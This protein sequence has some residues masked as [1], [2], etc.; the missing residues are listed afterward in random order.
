MSAQSKYEIVAL[1]NIEVTVDVSLLLKNDELFFNAT[2]IAKQFNKKPNEWL[3]SKQASEYIAVILEAENFRYENLVRTATGGKYQGTWLHKKLAL[4]FARWLSVKFEYEL[5]QWIVSR[6]KQEND[7][8]QQ[9]LEARTG[10]L[11]L[12][13]AIQS[14]HAEPKSYHFSNECNL[15]NRIVTGMDAKA[16]KEVHGVDSV[17]DAL[18]A[19][20]LRRMNE[21]QA[22][23]TALIKLGFDYDRRKELLTQFNVNALAA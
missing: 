17:R 8:K 1:N 21:L 7:K 16:F 20:E 19:D 9:R 22:C 3:D 4:P 23:D 18:C 5:D 15:I 11:P 12:T 6:L 14:A 10:F 13:N 2:D